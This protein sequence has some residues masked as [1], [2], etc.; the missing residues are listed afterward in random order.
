M[1]QAKNEI[2]E[3]NDKFWETIRKDKIGN[4]QQKIQ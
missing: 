1:N 4:Q 2:A 3:D